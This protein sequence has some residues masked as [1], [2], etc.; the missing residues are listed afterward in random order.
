M[1]ASAK[2]GFTYKLDGRNQF[3]VQA[4][5]GSRAPLADNVFIAPRVKNTTIGNPRP[6]LDFSADASYVWNYRRFRGTISAFY[7]NMMHAVERTGFYDEQ[8]NTYAI[9]ALEGVKREYKGVELGMAYKI[10]PSITATF[11]GT[12]ARF[13]Y[14]NNPQ[15]TRSF[16][17]G[18]YPDVTNT[19]YLKN[20]YLGSTPQSQFNVGVDYAAPKN[21]FFN[22]NGTWQ[23]DAYVN[24][25][26][27]YHEAMPGL[28]TMY[29]TQA[30]ILAKIEELAHQDKLDS[31]FT[32]NLSIGKAI[33][34]RKG[35]SLNFNLNINNVL[36]NRD[37][38]TYAYQQG[39][40]DTKNYDR[41][42]Y[43]NRYQY[44]Q[45]IRLFFNFGVRF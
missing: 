17:N 7:T 29:P 35:P 36:N 32:L 25:S 30:E 11:A 2:V 3:L 33:Y 5:Y 22:V 10:T 38:V 37:V 34:L 44:A 45:G 41:N 27:A 20:Y 4:E 1:T 23:G 43:P 8:Y 24:L 13:Q 19:V 42:A 16:E 15:G 40:V 26:P 9:F 21:W 14:K 28:A 39:R 31:H 6:Q 18:L 12:Y